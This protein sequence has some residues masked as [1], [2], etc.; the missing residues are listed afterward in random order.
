MSTTKR[1]RTPVEHHLYV[2]TQQRYA[3]EKRATKEILSG[4][5][6]TKRAEAIQG[7]RL[8]DKALRDYCKTFDIDDMTRHHMKLECMLERNQINLKRIVGRDFG[9]KTDNLY[10]SNPVSK[11]VS[12]I[13]GTSLFMQFSQPITPVIEVDLEHV[14]QEVLKGIEVPSVTFE[15]FKNSGIPKGE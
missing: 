13:A 14:R 1:K 6:P 2:L 9:Y 3:A 11:P 5:S 7:A 4:L 15:I 12:A 10:A 8:A